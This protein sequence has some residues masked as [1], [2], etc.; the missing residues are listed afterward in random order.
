MN[1]SFIKVNFDNRRTKRTLQVAN[2]VMTDTIHAWSVAK[3]D[4]TDFIS[5]YDDV[6]PRSIIDSNCYDI[7]AVSFHDADDYVIGR[8]NQK[9]FA[10]PFDPK[11]HNV[12]I[13]YQDA[14]CICGCG[15]PQG[16]QYPKIKNDYQVIMIPNDQ[17]W[18]RYGWSCNM[19]EV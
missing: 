1:H 18:N 12:Q 5:I 6:A 10:I 13:D 2:T 19:S 3:S 8:T 9:P 16:Y 4:I 11:K 17:W 15:Q 7:F 14:Y